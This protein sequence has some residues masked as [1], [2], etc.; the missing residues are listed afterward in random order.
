MIKICGFVSLKSREYKVIQNRFHHHSEES[1]VPNT[2]L[3]TKSS[4][5]LFCLEL[6]SHVAQ[7]VTE[8]VFPLLH[9]LR[10]ELHACTT[11]LV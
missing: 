8:L 11:L 4:A 9:L 5:F 7:A 10:A 1:A 3:L 6:A 2:E